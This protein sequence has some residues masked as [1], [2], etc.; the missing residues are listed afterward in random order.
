MN[1]RTLPALA[2]TAFALSVVAH[3]Q[4]SQPSGAIRGIVKGRDGRALSGV[5]VRIINQETG[6]SRS[7]KTGTSGDFSFPLVLSGTYDV[8]FSG[9]GL[10]PIKDS[11]VHVTLGNSAT[12]NP[13]METAEAAATVEVVAAAG[14]V[15]RPRSTACPPSTRAWWSRFPW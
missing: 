7:A 6:A 2:L 13:V 4:T 1:R 3:A 11:N 10:K 5:T 14:L 9:S 8:T 15:T 12:V